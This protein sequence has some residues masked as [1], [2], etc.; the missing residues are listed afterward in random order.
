[1]IARAALGA[2]IGTTT[3]MK[4]L[5]ANRAGRQDYCNSKKGAMGKEKDAAFAES[6]TNAGR[7]HQLIMRNC[8]PVNP[9]RVN[10]ER[11]QSTN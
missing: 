3:T 9:K 5:A 8:E 11:N 7:Y 6:G 2:D 4:Y 1:L 10:C